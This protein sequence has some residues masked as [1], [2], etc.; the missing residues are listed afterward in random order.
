MES[1]S[2]R[3]FF[4]EQH[5]GGHPR[6]LKISYWQYHLSAELSPAAERK[7]TEIRQVISFA[8]QLK[9][10]SV[11]TISEKTKTVAVYQ[12]QVNTA[13]KNRDNFYNQNRGLLSAGI[14]GGPGYPI[15]LALW[16]TMNNFHQAYFREN[17]ALEQESH[18][19]NL[20]RSDLA[21][22]EQLL[23]ENNRLLRGH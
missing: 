22:A 1:Q 3:R 8:Q 10:S 9:E 19:L 20:A 13:A 4:P 11:A 6:Y 7:L 21:K 2:G 12:E 15:Y 17:N 14:T 5:A 16:Q 23:A 18:V